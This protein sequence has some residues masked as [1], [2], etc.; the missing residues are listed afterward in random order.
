MDQS[1]I[2]SPTAFSTT[3]FALATTVAASAP[4]AAYLCSVPR[5][6]CGCEW[7]RLPRACGLLRGNTAECRGVGRCAVSCA[8]VRCKL[9]WLG[10]FLS[11]LLRLERCRLRCRY[12]GSGVRL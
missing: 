10:F 5:M 7:Q 4:A 9:R 8:C 3:T 12:D 11:Q 6:H 1:A 2:Y